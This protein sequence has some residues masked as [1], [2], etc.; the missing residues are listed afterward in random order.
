LGSTWS[1]FVPEHVV[2]LLVEH[3]HAIPIASTQPTPAVV[4]FADVVGFTTM[5]EALGGV[6]NYGTEELT[7]ILNG[8]FAAM[9]DL[10][11]HHGGSVAEFAGDALTALFPYDRQTRRS[12]LRRAIRCALH[13]Q[14]TTAGFKAVDTPAGIF[15]LAMKAGLGTGPVLQTVMG[16][17]AIRLQY[18]LAG[19]A[20][21]RAA[22]AQHHA[23]SH[24][25]VLDSCLLEDGLDAEIQHQRGRWSV[26]GSLHRALPPVPPVVRRELPEGAVTRLAPFLHPA[27]AE[28]LRSGRREFVNEHRKVTAVFVGLPQ[29]AVDDPLA[30]S[31]FQR[32]LVAAIRAIDR[33]GGHLR[34]VA[35]DDQGTLLVAF[36]GAP[37][38]HEDD[39]ERAVR[40]CLEL[41]QLPGG[42]FRAGV[43]TGPV[44]CG[45]IG[46]DTR[47]EYAVIGDSV[48]LAARLVQA[49]TPG[50]LLVDQPTHDRLNPTAI[51]H[52]LGPIT[53]KGKRRPIGVWVVR[54]VR[55]QPQRRSP[56]PASTKPLFGRASELTTARALLER[57]KA[58]KGQI[59]CLTGEAG[60]GKSRLGAE[61][62]DMAQRSGF[63]VHTGACRSYATTTSYLVW[64]PI[65][66][67]LLGLDS[68]L[69]IPEQRAIVVDA[70][71]QGDGG[72]GRR[73]PL[74]A[75]V[76]NL[77]I[78]DSQLTAPLDPQTRDELLRSLLL[79]WL[80][81]HATASPLLLLLE[82]CHWIDPSSQALLEF[83]ARNIAE[84]PVLIV[85]ITRTGAA[86]SPLATLAHCTELRLSELAAADALELVGQRLRQR[87]GTDTRLAPKLVGWIADRGEGNPFYLEELVSYL[88]T[89]G[90]DPR[91]VEALE[92]L[93]LPDGLQ[94]LMMAR[95][96]Q[97]IEDEKATIKVASV[98]GRRFRAS[99]ISRIHPAAGRP[100]EVASHLERLHQLDL[101]PRAAVVAEPEA[102]PEPEYEFK[103]A[104]THEAAYTSLTFRLRETLHERVGLLIEQAYP[105]RLAQYV[106]LLAHHYARTQRVDKQRWWFRAAGDAAAAAFANQAAVD[107][108]QR[109]LRL[110]PDGQ[111]GGVLVELGT[112]WRLTGHWADAEQAYRQ[113]MQIASRAGHREVLAASQRQ[114]GDLY[115]FTQSYAEAVRWLTSAAGEFEQLGDQQG[116]SK[117]L[118]RITYARYQQ[119]AYGQALAA[120]ERHL[121][122][123]TQAGDLAGISIALNHTGLVRLDTG[124]PTAA[125]ALLQ[126]A[127]DTATRAG[128]RRGL[129]HAA[130][131][132]GL[133]YWRRGDHLGAVTHWH[134]AL[135]VAE[136]IGDRQTAGI[137]IGNIGAVYQE[138]GDTLRATKCFVHALRIAVELGDWTSVADQVASMAATAAANGNHHQA[139]RLFAQA[140]AVARLLDAP[141][142][143]CDWLHQQ[144]CLRLAQD[145]L[146]EAEQLN[147]EAL[148]IAATGNEQEV[149]TRARLLALRLQ[150]ALGRLDAQTATGRLQDPGK[151]GTELPSRAAFLETLW[152]LDPT[153][154]ATRQAAA[155]L[156]HQLYLRSPSIKYRQAYAELTGATLPPGPPLPQLPDTVQDEDVDVDRVLRLVDHA[157]AQARYQLSVRVTSESVAAVLPSVPG[158]HPTN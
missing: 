150:V 129:L 7:R 134:Q 44:Y 55:E 61:V 140:I 53:V 88:H 15:G 114:L 54:A 63:S 128:D 99:W 139:D 29:L 132:L 144:A 122:L 146:A 46:S 141:Y 12:A 158:S 143:L 156:Y 115:M 6:G 110:L 77:P 125:L 37:I 131:N 118:D 121:Q 137:V 31:G 5:S 21:N 84:H 17:P 101:T 68:S 155:D 72:S 148:A 97:L 16:D 40:C 30:L 107:Y 126:Q 89:R 13:M 133:V 57:T 119:G 71:A 18:L 90:I 62:V 80:R 78:P 76:V 147:Q 48:N 27:I 152:R 112:V 66:R 104:I 81:D 42:P 64:R 145:R 127:L 124:Q 49:A 60:I 94:R 4:V 32:R 85:V 47:R 142:F 35:S 38:S 39:E 45:E 70:I 43:T 19:P 113:A 151:D 8:W 59:I 106:D 22:A 50:Q 58:G 154:E 103:H 83:L 136:E 2:Q 96:D 86:P 23:R 33:Y 9:T 120:A 117:T 98:I 138:Q 1:S 36:F 3:P 82:D 100:E 102:V 91:D 73:A 20:L 26:I 56:N 153:Q 25:V 10:T 130:N 11:C 28:R 41:L 67:D 123:A 116:L 105:D 157:A 79:D 135:P 69:P 24:E 111:S 92:A 14:A 75:P 51:Q 93:E 149:Q 109:L 108:Y 52:S 65:W 87:Y 95:I 74:L 34:Q